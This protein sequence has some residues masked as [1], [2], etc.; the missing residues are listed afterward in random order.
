MRCVPDSSPAKLTFQ[1]LP[2]ELKHFLPGIHR[3]L[4]PVAVRVIVP[5]PVTGA[6]VA[7]ELIVLSVLLQFFF[8]PV[9]LLPRRALVVVAKDAQQGS[10]QVFGVVNRGDRLGRGQ[11]LTWR[12]YPSAPAVDGARKPL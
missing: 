12:N 3:L 8:V 10:G 5:E 1:V 4:R 11:L 7:V 2:E 6:I 9:Y